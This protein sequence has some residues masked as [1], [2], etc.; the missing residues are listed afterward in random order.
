[1]LFRSEEAEQRRLE[2][3]ARPTTPEGKEIPRVQI[4]HVRREQ[5]LRANVTGIATLEKL[6]NKIQRGGELSSEE[7]S[8]VLKD[9]ENVGE[10]LAEIDAR[11]SLYKTQAEYP[12][13]AEATRLRDTQVKWRK[14]RVKSLEKQRE[15][16]MQVYKQIGRAHV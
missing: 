16:L 9:Y 6:H 12:T 2:Q 3:R 5:Y 15:D 14:D 10:Q 7:R 1:M 11:I 13:F 8:E 4:S